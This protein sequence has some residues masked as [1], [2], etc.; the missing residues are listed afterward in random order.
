MVGVGALGRDE[1]D[2]PMP[3]ECRPEAVVVSPCERCHLV[4]LWIGRKY[5]NL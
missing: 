4:I 2:A 3:P 5:T 1:A